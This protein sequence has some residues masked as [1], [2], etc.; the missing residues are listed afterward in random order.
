MKYVVIVYIVLN[1]IAS[2][3]F[4]F[5]GCRLLNTKRK[6][7]R[8]L[9]AMLSQQEH[10]TLSQCKKQEVKL[11]PGDHSD[12]FDAPWTERCQVTQI[13]EKETTT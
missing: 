5:T 8:G 3:S 6:L 1:L 4:K 7:G 2:A 10:T 11:L 12:L 13:K 9:G